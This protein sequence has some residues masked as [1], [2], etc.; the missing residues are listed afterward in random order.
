MITFSN[1]F[2]ATATAGTVFVAQ[3]SDVFTNPTSTQPTA[4]FIVSTFSANSYSIA[5]V[6]TAIT[7]TMDT[8]DSFTT[9]SMTRTSATNNAVTTYHFSFSQ[10]SPLEASSKLL[11]TFP[12]DVTP[13]SSPTCTITLPAAQA[14]VVACTQDGLTL[15]VT[16]PATIIASGTT[17][18]FDISD[19]RN[20]PSFKPSGSY[21]FQTKT[22]NSLYRYSYGIISPALTNTVPTSFENIDSLFVPTI[23]G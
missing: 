21:T 18:E 4:S 10:Q 6:S 14:G 22:S 5:E 7:V 9:S 16:L 17:V 1:P 3:I 12:S 2:T 8:A 13:S 19:V 11:L 15:T 20:P 23:L